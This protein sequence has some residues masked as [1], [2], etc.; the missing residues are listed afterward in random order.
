ME[1]L[2]SIEQKGAVNCGQCVLDLIRRIDLIM[3]FPPISHS[4][5]PM[6]G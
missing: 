3:I 5:Y 2:K 6:K 4:Y 1:V